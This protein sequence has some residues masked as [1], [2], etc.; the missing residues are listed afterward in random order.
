VGCVW[1]LLCFILA[2]GASEISERRSVVL[3]QCRQ[4]REKHGDQRDGR[5]Q[6]QAGETGSHDFGR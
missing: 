4:R 2:Q 6:P 1:L 3:G 5:D